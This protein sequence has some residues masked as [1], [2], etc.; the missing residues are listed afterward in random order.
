[1]L[2]L[3]CLAL[4][5]QRAVPVHFFTLHAPSMR[6]LLR[7]APEWMLAKGDEARHKQFA[8]LGEFINECRRIDRIGGAKDHCDGYCIVAGDF[9]ADVTFPGGKTGDLTPCA[10]EAMEVVLETMVNKVGLVDITGGD[11]VPTFGYMGKE[12]LLTNLGSRWT[13]KTDDLIFVDAQMHG[14]GKHTT[15]R[16]VSMSVED[17]RPKL[18]FTHVSDHWGVELVWN[19]P[20]KIRAV[21]ECRSSRTNFA[22]KT[23]GSNTV[24]AQRWSL[25]VSCVAL[26]AGIAHVLQQ[27]GHVFGMRAWN[28][29]PSSFAARASGRLASTLL[30][31]ALERLRNEKSFAKTIIPTTNLPLY[32]LD[33]DFCNIDRRHSDDIPIATF[34]SDYA[35]KR[36]V[37]LT[38]GERRSSEANNFRKRTLREPLIERF[39]NNTVILSASNSYTKAKITKSLSAYINENMAGEQ[40]LESLGNE[41]LYLFGDNYGDEWDP[42]MEHLQPNKFAGT[43]NTLSFGLGAKGSGVPFHFHGGGFSEVFYGRKR[44][45]L[46]PHTGAPPFDPDHSMLQW[47][48]RQYPILED[49]SFAQLQECTIRPGEMLYFPSGWWHGVLNLDPWT[50]FVSTFTLGED[51]L[52]KP[53]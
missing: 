45:F 10:G 30:P 52:R 28:L 42:L 43:E 34:V 4:E 51:L 49:N 11:L 9:N 19:I 3:L 26:F 16:A 12:Q 6:N 32:N 36:P 2:R 17:V 46:T 37:I 1:M 20:Q 5:L 24:A 14:K 23:A 53:L 50:S 15:W 38:Y 40:T 33:T 22:K 27:R 44:W 29:L 35:G 18:P 47:V 39:G 41:T 25:L 48:H 31:S 13:Y 7:G 21:K 8:E